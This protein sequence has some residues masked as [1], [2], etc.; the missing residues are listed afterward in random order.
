MQR[1]VRPKSA[2]GRVRPT[3]TPP[4]HPR[5]DSSMTA[6]K[7]TAVATNK[8]QHTTPQPSTSRRNMNKRTSNNE[9]SYAISR[10]NDE[11]SRKKDD[12]RNSVDP[13]ELPD[14][15]RPVSSLSKFG[16]LPQIPATPGTAAARNI[17]PVESEIEMDLLSSFAQQMILDSTKSKNSFVTNTK[18]P[19][20]KNSTVQKQAYAS[21]NPLVSQ[22]MHR[23]TNG[24]EA[25]RTIFNRNPKPPPKQNVSTHQDGP[26]RKKS[27]TSTTTMSVFSQNSNP[28]KIPLEPKEGQERLKIALKLPDGRRVERYFSPTDS[29]NDVMAFAQIKMRI[30]TSHC[31]IYSMIQV[32]KVLIKNW[33]KTL[34][35]LDIRDRTILYIDKKDEFSR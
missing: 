15:T 19:H 13:A 22:S 28:S 30:P 5:V 29:I 10:K 6:S 24:S 4:S 35:Q 18:Q 23:A 9:M 31:D 14:V 8:Q 7:P 17:S 34:E 12:T 25:R 2:K 3:P 16:I 1:P 20:T 11:Q 27:R 32:P 33:K 21:H 26:L